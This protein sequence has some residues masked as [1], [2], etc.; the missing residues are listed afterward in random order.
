MNQKLPQFEVK[1]SDT[2]CWQRISEVS[3]LEI[4]QENFD[5]ISPKIGEMLHGKEIET[6]MGVF[7]I[8]L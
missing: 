8:T 6:P 7:R 5:L 3:A 1:T 4:L 2:G